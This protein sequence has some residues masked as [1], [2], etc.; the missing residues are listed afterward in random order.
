M[1]FPK[2]RKAIGF[3]WVLKKKYKDDYRVDKY[4]ARL[5]AKGFT[6][7]PGIDFEDIYSLVVIVSIRILISIVTY[8]DLEL[9][10]MHVKMTVLDEE[11]KKDIYIQQSKGFK[12]Q[13]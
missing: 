10:Q 5:V 12:I 6:Q 4:K 3:K 9:Y 13:G 11:L 8:M 7:Q 2:N 1:D